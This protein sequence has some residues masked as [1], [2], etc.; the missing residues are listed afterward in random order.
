MAVAAS[1]MLSGNNLFS[2]CLFISTFVVRTAGTLLCSD[3]TIGIQMD[4]EGAAKIQ[5]NGCTVPGI[6]NGTTIGPDTPLVST[7]AGSLTGTT[8]INVNVS[9]AD[10]SFYV[11][12]D[13]STSG[14]TATNV[15][16]A[17]DELA[18]SSG[19]TTFDDSTFRIYN[20]GD[21]TKKIAFD[22]SS[23]TTGTTRTITMPNSNINLGNLAN[24]TLSNLGTTS[25][26]SDLMPDLTNSR[27]LG[28]GKLS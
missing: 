5:L 3:C 19:P 21:N 7:D 12:Y 26:N 14:L 9:R 16:D 4:L 11:N 25:I 17:I 22:A 10:N 2:N 8:L 23:I 6:L 27:N 18:G 13:N 24:T 1:G 15:K 28:G 20:N